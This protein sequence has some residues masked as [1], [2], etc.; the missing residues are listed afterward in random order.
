MK[1][2][3]LGYRTSLIFAAF[4]GEV[5]DRGSYLVIRTPG[6][7][8]FYWGNYLLFERPP[9]EGDLE[10]WRALFATEIGVPPVVKHEVFGWDSAS[11][12]PAQIDPF[13]RQGFQLEHSDVM[14]ARHPHAPPR[15]ATGLQIRALADDDAEWD[16]CVETQVINRAPEFAEAD[17]RLFMQRQMVRYRAMARAGL[18]AWYGAFIAGRLVADLGIFAAE[19]VGRY[20]YVQTHPDFQRRGIAATLVHEAGRLAAKQF[21]IQTLVIVATANS[22]AGRVYQSVGYRLVEP[23]LGLTR[24]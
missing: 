17:H 10:R 9:A 23:Q 5:I 15:P 12:E 18:G 8:G 6:N 2:R 24:W 11:D 19:G 7:P 4:D 3:S 13:L 16:R 14:A 22:A 20:Q 1:V 21:D